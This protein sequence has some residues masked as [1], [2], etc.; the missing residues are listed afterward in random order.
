M[1]DL[2]AA[3]VELKRKSPCDFDQ[4]GAWLLFRLFACNRLHRHPGFEAK[5]SP[6]R[7]RNSITCNI[8]AAL[9]KIFAKMKVDPEK[10]AGETFS[11]RGASAD[12][13]RAFIGWL[14]GG[15]IG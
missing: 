5:A 6:G 10:A 7:C 9:T 3:R 2:P 8:A 13:K 15:E 14:L 11:P 12:G 4:D 1:Q